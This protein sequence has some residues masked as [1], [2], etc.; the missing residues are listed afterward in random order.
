MS[1]GAFAGPAVGSLIG[2]G[3]SSAGQSSANRTNIMLQRNA[4]NFNRIEASRSRN[5]THD[6]GKRLRKWQE[7][8]SNTS[9]QRSVRDLEKAGLNPLLA[10]PG[11]ASSPGGGMGQG[12]AASAMAP[13][14][15]NELEGMATGAMSAAQLFQ[16][17]LVQKQQVKN[18]KQE[19]KNLEGTLQ[20]IKNMNQQIKATTA[21]TMADTAKS[22]METKV[23]SKEMPKADVM[24][25]FYKLI[26]P[27]LDKTLEAGQSSSSDWKIH[28]MKMYKLKTG[29]QK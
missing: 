22:N 21:K 28:N 15:E 6:E 16:Q 20:N 24:N 9:F 2:G 10:L 12:S 17:G 27:L 19:K 4:N 25:K 8:M 26:Q 18:M 13:S 5:F 14:V 23:L 3:F 1:W 11:G 7:R 29:G